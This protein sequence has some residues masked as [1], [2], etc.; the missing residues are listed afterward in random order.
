MAGGSMA[1]HGPM[2]QGRFLASLGAEARLATLSA[3]ADAAR[4][5]ALASGVARLLDPAGMGNLFQVLALTSPGLP[6][7]AGFEQLT[8]S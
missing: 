1:V 6:T 3:R 7:P 8:G 5:G 4:H 2:P